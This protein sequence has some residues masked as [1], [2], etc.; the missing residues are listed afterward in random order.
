MPDIVVSLKSGK[1]SVDLPKVKASV[2]DHQ[3]VTWKSHDGD[4][5]IEFKAGSD[6]PNPTT[7][8]TG[9]V[10]KAETGP[11]TAAG[12]TLR[13]NVKATGYD[14]LDPEIEIIP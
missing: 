9:G 7:T 2:K 1:I 13:Y 10:W 14:T 6:W 8:N 12:S 4:F 3:K 11:F 5:Q